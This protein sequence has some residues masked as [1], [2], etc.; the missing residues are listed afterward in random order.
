LVAIMIPTFPKAAFIFLLRPSA[1]SC[2]NE[3]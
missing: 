3:R 1:W 2:V